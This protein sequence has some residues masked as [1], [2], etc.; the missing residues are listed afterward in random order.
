MYFTVYLIIKLGSKESMY[1]Y[2]LDV[3]GNTEINKLPVA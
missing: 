3:Q 2:F 1:L